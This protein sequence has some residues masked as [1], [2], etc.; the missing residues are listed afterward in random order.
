MHRINGPFLAFAVTVLAACGEPLST[1]VPV[2]PTF[3]L[4]PSGSVVT[5]GENITTG[6]TPVEIDVKPGSSP[7][8]INCRNANAVI[9]VA[10]LTNDHFDATTVDH[11]TVVFASASE[12]H[13]DRRTGT[14]R[15]HEEDV[16]A[17]GDLDLVFHFNYGAT[18]LTCSSTEGTLEGKTFD[19]VMI[20]GT[21]YVRSVHADDSTVPV[22][23]ST[24]E[25][26]FTSLVRPTVPTMAQIFL[27]Y[28]G[29]YNPPPC[30]NALTT[31]HEVQVPWGT[32]LR[33]RYD[34]A[35]P[36]FAGFVTCLVN[37]TDEHLALGIEGVSAWGVEESRALTNAAPDLVGNQVEY[38]ELEVDQLTATPGPGGYTVTIVMRWR[39]FGIP[40]VTNP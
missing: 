19:G 35:D 31:L 38:L 16:D 11:A 7:N 26:P 23:L 1:D 25:W 15:R 21:D 2:A 27:Y 24:L 36:N 9:A 13:V 37:G 12:I 33:H 40:E 29:Y 28:N 17:D 18:S 6:A 3:N 4:D 39:I 30:N 10:I 32:T 34:A 20:R 8:S 5:V 22:L 14:P